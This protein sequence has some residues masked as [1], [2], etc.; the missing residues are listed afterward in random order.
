MKTDVKIPSLLPSI[1][2]QSTSSGRPIQIY[3]DVAIS[4]LCFKYPV[5]L[6]VTKD[7]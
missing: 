4:L 1:L 3:M 2:I 5:T 6:E 7:Y